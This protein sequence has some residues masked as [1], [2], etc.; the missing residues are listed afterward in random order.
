MRLS[1]GVVF[2]FATILFSC[3]NGKVYQKFEDF[4]D[5]HWLLAD[6]VGF[7][8][9]LD[10]T[11]SRYNLYCNLRNSTQYPYSRVFINFQMA[12][13]LGRSIHQTMLSDFL[14]DPKTGKPF[15]KTG[16]GDLY[17]HQLPVLKNHTFSGKGP[18]RISLQQLMRT[19]T[20]EGVLS[21]GISLER[22]VQ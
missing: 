12:D 20:L 11:T 22:V 19:D 21:V 10:D 2:L 1:V 15:G 18:Y 3:G 6:T 9:S 17:D 14:F 7:E 4:P 5:R 16:L 13:T 8:F